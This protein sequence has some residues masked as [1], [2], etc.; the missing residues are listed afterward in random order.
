M[1]DNRLTLSIKIVLSDQDD[2][3]HPE[4]YASSTTAA[5]RAL[6]QG[7]Y[8]LSESLSSAIGALVNAWERKHAAPE[9]PAVATPICT[10]GAHGNCS[11]PSCRVH[12]A[13]CPC[14]VSA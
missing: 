11:N 5:P 9:A 12:T 3:R 8:G 1:N 7:A 14:Y 13:D 2:W 6:A 10:C 4:R